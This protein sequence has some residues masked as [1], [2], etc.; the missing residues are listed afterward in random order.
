MNLNIRGRDLAHLQGQT[1][2]FTFHYVG[3]RTSIK[4]NYNSEQKATTIIL[5]AIN[6]V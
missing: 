5:F 1:R 6:I 2:L 4:K 3:D